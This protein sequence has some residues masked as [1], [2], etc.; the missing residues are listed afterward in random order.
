MPRMSKEMSFKRTHLLIFLCNEKKELFYVKKFLSTKQ[1][2]LYKMKFCK[3][4][5]K[6][7]FH[8]LHTMIN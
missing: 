6:L 3:L 4:R 7:T 1:M 8:N 2:K 5:F